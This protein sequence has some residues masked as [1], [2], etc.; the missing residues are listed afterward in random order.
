MTRK[1]WFIRHA[2]SFTNSGQSWTQPDTNP[3]TETG[4]R[5]AEMVCNSLTEKPE[6]IITSP[7][8]RTVET[9]R[10][11]LKRWPEVEHI[12]WPIHEFASF[13]HVKHG[14]ITGDLWRDHAIE[15]W[16]RGDPDYKDG[17]EA[18]SF[19]ELMD[20]ID[21]TVERILALKSKKTLIFSHGFFLG[22]L[23][24]RLENR[25]P[26]AY[27]MNEVWEYRQKLHI[28]NTSISYFN[29][30]DDGTTELHSVSTDHLTDTE[31]NLRGY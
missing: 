23:F 1:I 4:H 22:I 21:N 28:P 12:E 27:S 5:Q 13:C 30:F 25:K 2:E 20:R 19:N 15:L 17:D 31:R 14:K 29:L 18:E 24:Y 9:A 6:L 16:E 3:L 26:K 10:P 7:Y 11:A 8:V